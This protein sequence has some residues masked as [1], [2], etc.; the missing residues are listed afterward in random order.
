MSDSDFTDVPEYYVFDGDPDSNIAPRRPSVDDLGGAAFEDDE[1]LPPVPPYE[2]GASAENQQERVLAGICQTIFTLVVSVEFSSGDPVLAGFS[3]TSTLL[4]SDD[5]TIED[6]GAGN[7][8]ITWPANM[9]PSRN[10]GPMLTL[11]EDV[12][13][14][15]FRAVMDGDGLGVVVKTKLSTTGTDCAFTV[16]IP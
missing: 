13:I 15:R 8:H 5:I 2:K 7:T 4:D 1:G 12:E 14:D 3:T 11:N 16:Y 10:V 6:D 9:L